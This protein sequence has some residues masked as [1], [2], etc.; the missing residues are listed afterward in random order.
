MEIN[1]N[2]INLSY[3]IKNQKI[4]QLNENDFYFKC[5]KNN[6][7]LI[8]STG[9]RLYAGGY[10]F[11]Y[12]LEKY[13]Y[14]FINKRICELGCGIGIIGICC[15]LLCQP[16]YILLTDGN[17]E[18]IE[19]TKLNINEF[20]LS[21]NSSIESKQLL[22][23]YSNNTNTTN[24]NDNDNSNTND[25][26]NNDN[27]NK[28][29]QDEETNVINNNDNINDKFDI[30]IGCELMYYKLDMRLLFT[31]V[32]N[33]LT[34]NGCFYHAHIFRKD[35]QENELY[36]LLL[37]MNWKSLEID[38]NT[39]VSQVELNEHADWNNVRCFVSGPIDVINE[40][41]QSN[42]DWKEFLGEKIEEIVDPFSNLDVF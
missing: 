14:L 24:D 42:S 31:T 35:S 41:S 9:L 28:V 25:S 38:I 16:S 29:N 40:L 37:E 12:F 33:L 21:N 2:E 11:I 20:N 27:D 32:Q 1:L 15:Y 13:S 17:L 34:S 10:V 36:T 4:F 30:V 39:F 19:I 6:S 18:A 22:W 23:S 8:D 7:N 5:L 3:K 26:D